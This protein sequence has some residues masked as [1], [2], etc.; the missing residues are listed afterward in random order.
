MLVYDPCFLV[1]IGLNFEH[2][3]HVSS[4]LH[5]NHRSC[6][7]QSTPTCLRWII[8]PKGHSCAQVRAVCLR[9]GDPGLC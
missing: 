9:C 7:V 5:I 3:E 6:V 4:C 8:S 2:D 1:V